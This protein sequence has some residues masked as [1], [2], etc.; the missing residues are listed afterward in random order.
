MF[1]AIVGYPTIIIIDLPKIFAKIT[2]DSIYDG[3]LFVLRV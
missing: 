2:F 3:G 1:I